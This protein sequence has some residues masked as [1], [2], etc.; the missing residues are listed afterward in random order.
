MIPSVRCPREFLSFAIKE[1]AKLLEFRHWWQERVAENSSLFKVQTERS[2]M[3]RTACM[4]HIEIT[5]SRDLWI[6]GEE[7]GHQCS[8]LSLAPQ[9]HFFLTD[10]HR[11]GTFTILLCA[12]DATIIVDCGQLLLKFF[13]WNFD[14]I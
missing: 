2:E 7:K 3:R 9:I 6:I 10:I 13:L 1:N 4:V 11:H 14:E 5:F 8:A 12:P